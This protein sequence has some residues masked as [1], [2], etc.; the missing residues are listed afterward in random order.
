MRMR[1]RESFWPWIRDPGGK[2]RIRDKLPGS[3]TLDLGKQKYTTKDKEK[4]HGSD[5]E[6]NDLY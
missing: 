1:I 6:L 3:A 4:C 2:I 5:S